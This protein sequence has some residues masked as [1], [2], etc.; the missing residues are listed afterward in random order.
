MMKENYCSPA[1]SCSKRLLSRSATCVHPRLSHRRCKYF[2]FSRTS[3]PAP[4]AVSEVRGSM[5]AISFFPIPRLMLQ[6][7][8]SS[9][10]LPCTT[11]QLHTP[12][13]LTAPQ[14]YTHTHRGCQLRL[15]FLAPLLI[16][17][18]SGLSLCLF[19]FFHVYFLD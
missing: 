15:L 2:L 9:L 16:P 4:V 7:L 3:A 18:S 1:K 11:I 6:C 19:S 5:S 8:G 13:L 10:K 17:F 12:L 14:T